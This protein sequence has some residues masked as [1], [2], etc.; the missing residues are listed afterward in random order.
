VCLLKPAL[1]ID[2]ENH[3]GEPT[4]AAKAMYEFVA[5]TLG[6]RPAAAAS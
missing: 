4:L 3:G 6:P 5:A 1:V 2:V